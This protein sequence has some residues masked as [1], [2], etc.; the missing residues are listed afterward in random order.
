M[1]IYQKTMARAFWAFLAIFWIAPPLT[2]L[3]PAPDFGT[4]PG[5]LDMFLHRP[6][7]A[8]P[9]M[10]MV[11][12]LHGCTKSAT[13]FDNE[14]GLIALAEE[15]PFMIVFPQQNID[16]MSNLC[17]QFYDED[18]QAGPGSFV[19][20]CAG[21]DSAHGCYRYYRPASLLRRAGRLC[22]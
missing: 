1:A 4:D 7:A 13:D 22:P 19:F 5:S 17:F 6:A 2:A 12:A 11:V 16:N 8:A 9:G 18:D 15:V 3:E 21:R 10:P 14:T 20:D